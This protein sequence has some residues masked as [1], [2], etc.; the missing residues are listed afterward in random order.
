MP[1]PG[2]HSADVYA[3]ALSYANQIAGELT[4]LNGGPV[5][6]PPDE[7]FRSSTAFFA[8]TMTFLQW[9]Q[10]VLVPRIQQVVLQGG[11]FPSASSVGAYAARELDG[12][13][14]A[15]PL[16]SL[17]AEFDAFV[18]GLPRGPAWGLKE[19]LTR[20]LDTV[21][22]RVHTELRAIERDAGGWWA[23]VLLVVRTRRAR[24]TEIHAALRLVKAGPDWDVDVPASVELTA[25]FRTGR[26]AELSRQAATAFG[27]GNT[28]EGQRL[29]G[30]A[31]QV[32]SQTTLTEAML[33]AREEP[34]PPPMPEIPRIHLE[35]IRLGQPVEAKPAPPPEKPPA[36]PPLPDPAT[37]YPMA[38]A[39]AEQY[40]RALVDGGGADLLSPRP[41]EASGRDVELAE[42]VF[43]TITGFEECIGEIEMAQEGPVVN[44]IVRA[45]RGLW[46]VRLAF[47]SRAAQEPEEEEILPGYFQPKPVKRRQ[48]PDDLAERLYVEPQL[49]Y[50]R[51]TDFYLRQHHIHPPFTGEGSAREFVMDFWHNLA[52]NRRD[53]AEKKLTPESRG[54]ELPEC[55][56]GWVDEIVFYVDYREEPLGVVVRVLINTREESRFWHTCAVYRAGEWMIDWPETLRR[57]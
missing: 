26:A 22:N 54:M 40:L 1:A 5:S 35:S 38:R 37:D 7:A 45:E 11:A 36:Q 34:P 12:M 42:R 8:D 32:A 46:V 20:F 47:W 39:V 49:S 50:L 17:L 28:E 21:P 44:A 27:N 19:A 2:A 53:W 16:V 23:H 30:E 6:A 31:G 55:G 51:T 25:R 10:F 24:E 3:R 4:K 33:R 48:N 14:E 52:N 9:L 18:E 29:L 56:H 41:D 57:N 43:R 13:D 15:G